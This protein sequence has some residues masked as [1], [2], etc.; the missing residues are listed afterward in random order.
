M[1][2]DGAKCGKYIMYN[3]KLVHAVVTCRN[4]FRKQLRSRRIESFDI[5]K[6]TLFVFTA[7]PNAKVIALQ[8]Q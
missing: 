7:T 5:I 6:H 8:K 1:L 3:R 2:K 4:C